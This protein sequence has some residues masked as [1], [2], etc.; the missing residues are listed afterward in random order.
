MKPTAVK[1]SNKHRGQIL[2]LL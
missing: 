1:V 2:R